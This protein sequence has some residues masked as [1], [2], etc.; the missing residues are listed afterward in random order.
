MSQKFLQAQRI[1]V[2][3]LI[4]KS[5]FTRLIACLENPYRYEFKNALKYK[6]I[7]KANGIVQKR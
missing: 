2:I 1:D 3:K 4:A 5:G 6:L 7:A